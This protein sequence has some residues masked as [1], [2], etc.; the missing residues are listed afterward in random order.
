M[1]DLFWT[2]QRSGGVYSVTSAD[3]KNSHS[4]TSATVIDHLIIDAL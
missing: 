3:T 2:K 4:T 1:R